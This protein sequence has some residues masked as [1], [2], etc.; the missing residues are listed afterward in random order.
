MTARNFF[1]SYICIILIVALITLILIRIINFK[2]D[3]KSTPYQQIRNRILGLDVEGKSNL[4]FCWR[5]ALKHYLVLVMFY[6]VIALF[7]QFTV[8][9]WL[10]MKWKLAYFLFYTVSGLFSLPAFWFIGK[11][12]PA[13][14]NFIQLAREYP[15][16]FAFLFTI[17]LICVD[18]GFTTALL[19][20]CGGLNEMLLGNCGRIIYLWIF[21]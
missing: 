18:F 2:T 6:L 12:N 15:K 13:V 8:F 21:G 7:Y 9:S 4:K 14:D 11:G 3:N 20:R 16:F 5:T 17:S 19:G 10:H 1:L